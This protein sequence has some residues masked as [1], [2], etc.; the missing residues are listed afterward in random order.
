M[1]RVLA[2]SVILAVCLGA[3]ALAG[4]KMGKKDGT[5][6]GTITKVDNDQ[7]MMTVT[8]KSGKEWSIYWNTDT[9]V[10]GDGPKEGVKVWFKATEKDGKMWATWVKTGE[11]KG[12]M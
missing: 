1:K 10:E 8:D 4:E 7:K 2:L 12:K 3:V 11:A 9:K 5:L 6:S